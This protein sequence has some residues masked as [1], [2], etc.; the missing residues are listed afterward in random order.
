MSGASNSNTALAIEHVAHAFGTRAVLSNIS[1]SIARGES[2]ALLG[3]NGTGKTTLVRLAAGL[4]RPDQGDVHVAGT[5]AQ[6]GRPDVGIA[7]QDARLMP[8]RS[9]ARNVSLPLE[10]AGED[11]RAAHTAAIAA[12]ARMQAEHLADRAPAD[13]SGGERQR[14]ALARALV[15]NPALVLLDEPFAALDALTRTRFDEQLPELVE[16][17]AIL[18]VTHDIGEALLV[19]DRVLVLAPGGGISLEVAG[20]RGTPQGERRAV[21]MSPAGATRQ[22]QLYDALRTA[23]SEAHHA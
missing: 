8:W 9:V 2:V 6:A 23:A 3:A 16:G 13:L 15:R 1:L 11:R 19:A 4:I 10:I 14:V 20:L 17:A 18:F 5:P 12:L 22:D 7:F 21:L